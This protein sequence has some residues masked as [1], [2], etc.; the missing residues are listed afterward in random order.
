MCAKFFLLQNLFKRDGKTID[1]F[2]PLGNFS[3]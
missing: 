3:A 1:N 2:H